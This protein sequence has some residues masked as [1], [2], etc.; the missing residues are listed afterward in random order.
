[1]NVHV[2][3][4]SLEREGATVLRSL[5]LTTYVGAAI[6]ISNSD[7]TNRFAKVQHVSLSQFQGPTMVASFLAISLCTCS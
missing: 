6:R 1:M 7:P 5:D 4:T 2:L 3:V